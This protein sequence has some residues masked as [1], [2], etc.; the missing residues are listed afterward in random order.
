MYYMGESDRWML[1]RDM[2]KKAYEFEKQYG[3][4]MP[5]LLSLML[6]GG[7]KTDV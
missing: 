4:I 1:A 3:F 7:K 5:Q 2:I 6:P